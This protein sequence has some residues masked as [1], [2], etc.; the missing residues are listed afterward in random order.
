MANRDLI[1]VGVDGTEGGRR[2]LRWAVS[3]ARRDGSTVAAVTAWYP[4]EQ[5]P[6][7]E[8]VSAR[9][10]NTA[11]ADGGPHVGVVRQVLAGRPANVLT[12]ASRGAGMLVLGSHGHGRLRQAALGSVSESCVRDASCPVVVILAT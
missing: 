4:V 1:V 9:E 6:F 8:R 7:A 12:E 3:E 2:A 5:R 10:V 11:L